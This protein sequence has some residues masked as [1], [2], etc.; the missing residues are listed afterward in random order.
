MAGCKNHRENVL[1]WAAKTE[2]YKLG[3]L[4]KQTKSTFHHSVGCNI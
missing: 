3:G 2:Y 1:D 4:N